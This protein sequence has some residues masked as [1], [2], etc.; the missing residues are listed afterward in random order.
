MGWFRL[1]LGIC[2]LACPMFAGG[3]VQVAELKEKIEPAQGTVPSILSADSLFDYLFATDEDYADHFSLVTTSRSLQ[4]TLPSRPKPIA[5]G[6]SGRFI[7]SFGDLPSHHRWHVVEAVA[8]DERAHSFIPMEA[9]FDPEVIKEKGHGLLIL[10]PKSCATCHFPDFRPNYPPY[11]DWAGFMGSNNDHVNTLVPNEASRTF[12]DLGREEKDSLTLFLEGDPLKGIP[13]KARKG[14]FARFNFPSH[15]DRTQKEDEARVRRNRTFN[16]RVGGWNR[17][18]IIHR[19]RCSK[20]YQD[21]KYALAAALSHCSNFSDF[22]KPSSPLLKDLATHL[23]QTIRES[24]NFLVQSRKE[25]HFRRI[26]LGGASASDRFVDDAE[27]RALVGEAEPI[28][29]GEIRYLFETL[30]YS[31]RGWSMDLGINR[32]GLSDGQAGWLA[33]RSY[34]WQVAEKDFPLTEEDKLFFQ[35][36]KPSF[37]PSFEDRRISEA[38]QRLSALRDKE[39]TEHWQAPPLADAC[40]K[41]LPRKKVDSLS[42]ETV[43]VRC[44]HCHVSPYDYDFY[45]NPKAGPYLRFDDALEFKKQLTANQGRLLK[46]IQRRISSNDPKFRMPPAPHDA[47]TEEEQESFRHYLSSLFHNRT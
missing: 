41:E 40:P 8:V 35:D 15:L 13:S 21:I 30:G 29:L 44:L 22:L 39:W 47:L 19:W 32:Y 31:T 5:Y 12:L 24:K 28:L 25:E 34:F 9:N 36:K 17:L 6:K 1:S 7:F 18:R 23:A 33:M 11:F 20:E 14:R 38:C 26:R 16:L 10:N 46:E 2:L 42:E 37:D 27:F 45:K 3:S 4:P 43:I